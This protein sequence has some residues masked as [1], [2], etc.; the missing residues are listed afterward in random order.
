MTRR[1]SPSRKPADEM[2]K[3]TTRPS[4]RATS[5]FADAE[6]AATASI[7]AGP[8]SRSVHGEVAG[9]AT[10]PALGFE[11]WRRADLVAG[12]PTVYAESREM[13]VPQM[14]NIDLLGGISFNKGCYTGQEI[15]ARLHYLGQLKRRMFLLRALVDARPGMPVYDA[16][17]DGQAVGEVV[18]AVADGDAT[19]LLAVLQLSHAG[20]AQLAL[21]SIDGPSLG[22]AQALA[23]AGQKDTP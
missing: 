6:P 10:L 1:Y 13:F 4:S 9:L 7:S 17:G 21:A 18:D 5:T 12:V 14:A 8:Y 22:P 2:V 23:P 16:A 3:P 19:L 11:A 20:S 15:V